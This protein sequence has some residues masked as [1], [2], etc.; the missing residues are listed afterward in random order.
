MTEPEANMKQKLVE[1]QEEIDEISFC[2]VWL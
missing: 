1:M 2:P